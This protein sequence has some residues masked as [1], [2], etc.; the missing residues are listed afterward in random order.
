MKSELWYSRLSYRLQLWN[1]MYKQ[2]LLLIQFFTNV[3]NKWKI[4]VQA[5]G[6]LRLKTKIQVLAPCFCLPLI[7]YSHLGNESAN[8][9]S[10]SFSLFPSPLSLPPCHSTFQMNEGMNELITHILKIKEDDPCKVLCKCSY[11]EMCVQIIRIKRH[12]F[13]CYPPHSHSST[14]FALAFFDLGRYSFSHSLIPSPQVKLLLKQNSLFIWRQR[15]RIFHSW[16]IFLTAITVWNRLKPGTRNSILVS[17]IGDR[18]PNTWA[19]PLCLSRHIC[20]LRSGT[21]RIQTAIPI[22]EA[23]VTNYGL[24]HCSTRSVPNYFFP[25]N[26]VTSSRPGTSCVLHQRMS[27]CINQDRCTFVVTTST[28]FSVC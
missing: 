19:I 8:Q 23:S 17:H 1:P 20:S 4:M 9:M 26:N 21:A 16:F 7:C 22:W 18:G 10:E 14:L 25:Q 27:S 5:L 24:T 3:P 28:V 13:S 6:A 15:K 2:H 12:L 11:F